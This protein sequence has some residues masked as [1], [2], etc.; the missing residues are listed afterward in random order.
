M[1]FIFYVCIDISIDT[2][3][4]ASWAIAS[5][6]YSHRDGKVKGTVMENSNDLTE[7]LVSCIV[8]AREYTEGA[9]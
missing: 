7:K 2:L 1:V 4:I 6:L 8:V 3:G 5:L 9:L